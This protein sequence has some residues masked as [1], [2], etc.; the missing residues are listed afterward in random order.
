MGHGE[1]YLIKRMF[2]KWSQASQRTEFLPENRIKD[3][4]QEFLSLSS[5]LLDPFDMTP[6]FFYDILFFVGNLVLFPKIRYRSKELHFLLMGMAFNNQNLVCS[7]LLGCLYFYAF[8]T[9]TVGC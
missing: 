9:D 3:I 4:I 6:L 2:Q 7:L 8:S 1:C 5:W